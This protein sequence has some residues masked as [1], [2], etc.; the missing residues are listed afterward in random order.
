MRYSQYY[1]KKSKVKGHL[2]Q[3]RFYSCVLE[4]KHLYSAVRYVENNPVRA[5]LV[6]HPWQWKWSSALF[7]TVEKKKMK[8]EIELA[9]MSEILSFKDTSWKEYISGKED[10]IVIDKIRKCTML[11]RPFGSSDFIKTLS[12]KIGRSL[13]AREK[14]RPKKKK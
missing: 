13:T 8:I 12:D 11:G 5:G 6:K 4:H 10:P 1:N 14:G 3:G 9:D 2:W 7:H